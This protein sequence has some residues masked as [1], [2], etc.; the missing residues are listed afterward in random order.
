MW[1]GQLAEKV[2]WLAVVAVFPAVES[3]VVVTRASETWSYI[4]IPWLIAYCC[5]CWSSPQNTTAFRNFFLV[6]IRILLFL[7]SEIIFQMVSRQKKAFFSL[8]FQHN[9]IVSRKQLKSVEMWKFCFCFKSSTAALLIVCM[10][11][12][13]SIT[14]I[15]NHTV[16]PVPWASLTH[17]NQSI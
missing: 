13:R 9:W 10:L 2:T 15:F 5:M 3:L 6:I 11:T 14:C 4:L 1:P 17:D 12:Y 16:P 8:F 7:Q